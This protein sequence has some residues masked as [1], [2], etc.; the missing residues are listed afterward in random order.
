VIKVAGI[1]GGVGTTVL[2]TILKANDVG[3]DAVHDADIVV[4]R[5]DFRCAQALLHAGLRPE[6][7]VVLIME[8]GRSLTLRDFE[9]ILGSHIRISTVDLDPA[10][11]RMD[12]A[13]LLDS[14]TRST[15]K[16]HVSLIRQG[17]PC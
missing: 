3:R 11:A 12:D 17:V 8:P 6:Q 1:A 5:N 10:V 4:A 13:G 16:L 2:A 14:D 9:D 15:Q 7:H